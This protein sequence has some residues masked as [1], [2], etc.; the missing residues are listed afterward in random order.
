MVK[1]EEVGDEEPWLALSRESAEKSL[2]AEPADSTRLRWL[3]SMKAA[4]G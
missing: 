4:E 2:K 3:M 1:E